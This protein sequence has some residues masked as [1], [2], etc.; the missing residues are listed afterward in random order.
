[1]EAKK[2]VKKAKPVKLTAADANV[3]V[4][5]SYP[6]KKGERRHTVAGVIRDNYLQVGYAVAADRDTF[7]K[8][9]GSEIAIGRAAKHPLFSMSIEQIPKEKIPVMFKDI[10]KNFPQ[11]FPALIANPHKKVKEISR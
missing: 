1:M 9:L 4:R 3:M 7:I 11:Q 8:K 6:D 2:K 5:H 10:V